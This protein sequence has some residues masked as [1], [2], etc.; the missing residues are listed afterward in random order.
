M[1]SGTGVQ[2]ALD[3][4]TYIQLYRNSFVLDTNFLPKE[5]KT[6]FSYRTGKQPQNRMSPKHECIK[7]PNLSLGEPLC[8]FLP[9]T[10]VPWRFLQHIFVSF[11]VSSTQRWLAQ[12]EVTPTL[13]RWPLRQPTTPDPEWQGSLLKGAHV[14]DRRWISPYPSAWGRCPARHRWRSSVPRSS[15]PPGPEGPAGR[16]NTSSADQGETNTHTHTQTHKQML[17]TQYHPEAVRDVLCDTPLVVWCWAAG[18]DHLSC[19]EPSPCL[20]WKKLSW[21]SLRTPSLSRSDTL[22]MRVRALTQRGFI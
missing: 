5:R 16:W 15:H 1:H 14:G 6:T 11:Q 9:L 4:V 7:K 12:W 10:R 21:L 22:K 17:N 20:T 19:W 18:P 2:V 8:C 3:N 13:T